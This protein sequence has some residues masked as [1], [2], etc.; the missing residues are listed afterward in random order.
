MSYLESSTEVEKIFVI[1]LYNTKFDLNSYGSIESSTEVEK[2]FV[3]NL[4]HA[5]FD[6]NS[7]ICTLIKIY[8]GDLINLKINLLVISY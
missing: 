6:F 2:I 8:H 7:I 5:K 1:N 4:Y 3:I